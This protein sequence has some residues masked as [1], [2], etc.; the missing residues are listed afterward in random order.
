MEKE[1]AELKFNPTSKS[2]PIFHNCIYW[3]FM[4]N[5]I[6]SEEEKHR[7]VLITRTYMN[8]P[9]CT[10]LPLTYKIIEIHLLPPLR[11][12]YHLFPM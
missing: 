7:P 9:I 10:V 1:K 2:F 6:G 12:V 11:R 8:S 4:G 5:N 3:A